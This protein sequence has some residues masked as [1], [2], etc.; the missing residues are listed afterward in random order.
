MLDEQQ[1]YS[2]VGTVDAVA[3]GLATFISAT[4]VDEVMLVSAIYDHDARLRSFE[5][6]ADAMRRLTASDAA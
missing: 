3:D 2:A 4:A 1:R 6:A 5:I